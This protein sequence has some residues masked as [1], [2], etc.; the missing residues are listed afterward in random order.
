M[1]RLLFESWK[2]LVQHKQ[3]KG[4]RIIGPARG[5]YQYSTLL[6]HAQRFLGHMSEQRNGSTKSSGQRHTAYCGCMLMQRLRKSR[7]DPINPS[8]SQKGHGL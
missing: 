7:E 5:A 4:V 3:A 8:V 2:C 1:L 6:S